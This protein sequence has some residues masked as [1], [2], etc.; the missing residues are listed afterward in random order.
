MSSNEHEAHEHEACVH[1][2]RI[3]LNTSA[4]FQLVAAASDD[5]VRDAAA[6]ALWPREHADASELECN[7]AEFKSLPFH[8]RALALLVA[9]CLDAHPERAKRLRAVPQYR[10]L[11]SEKECADGESG[12]VFRMRGGRR[13]AAVTMPTGDRRT[14]AHS[15]AFVL[16]R[17]AEDTVRDLASWG[18]VEELP[19]IQGSGWVI[20]ETSIRLELGSRVRRRA[21]HTDIR[22]TLV[23]ASGEVL[24]SDLLV[25]AR[26][27]GGSTISIDSS[28]AMRLASG[29]LAG[30]VLSFCNQLPIVRG[31]RPRDA[32]LSLE[33]GPSLR[34]C[35]VSTQFKGDLRPRYELDGIV[36]ARRV[37]VP[38][39]AGATIDELDT[40][41]REVGVWHGPRVRGSFEHHPLGTKDLSGL[42]DDADDDS[43]EDPLA[44]ETAGTDPQP[45]GDFGWNGALEATFE[46]FGL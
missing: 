18:E 41:A 42:S 28:I 25:M 36:R 24:R 27:F 6:H 7:N 26:L 31:R 19:Y 44:C 37:Q 39:L 4:A 23:S 9:A 11:V 33:I 46:A 14:W 17:F 34:S 2:S 8:E 10:F 15:A 38:T 30:A 12:R 20:D 40:I 13:G 5:E 3:T 43:G 1:E 22:P 45:S 35:I 16:P 32:T 21:W 29:G